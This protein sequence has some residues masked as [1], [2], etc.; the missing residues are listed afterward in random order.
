MGWRRPLKS[1]L[2]WTRRSRPFDHMVS[3]SM[4]SL[5]SPDSSANQ[6][7]VLVYLAVDI[8]SAIEFDKSGQHLATRDRGGRVVLFERTY[9][10]VQEKKVKKVSVMNLSPSNGPGNESPFEFRALEV[11]L[12][13]IYTFFDARTT[14]LES[15]AYPTLDELTSKY[16]KPHDHEKLSQ[17]ELLVIDEA[18]AIPLPIV[19]SILWCGVC[20]RDSAVGAMVTSGL[21]EAMF[22]G[23]PASDLGEGCVAVQFRKNH[24]YCGHALLVVICFIKVLDSLPVQFSSHVISVVL[25]DTVMS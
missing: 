7:G 13:A 24:R 10:K 22:G 23:F 25:G 20:W 17:I 1:R 5:L 6:V 8:I 12:E 9:I 2:W 18:A 4:R 21:G 14:E 16:M 15:G 11:T 3:A 19:K